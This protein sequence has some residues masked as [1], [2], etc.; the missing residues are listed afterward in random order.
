MATTIVFTLLLCAGEV[1]SSLGAD[2]Y[3]PRADRVSTVVAITS[4]R[5]MMLMDGQTYALTQVGTD[6]YEFDAKRDNG[7]G[8]TSRITGSIELAAARSRLDYEASGFYSP[9]ID[10][11][12]MITAE[13]KVR[14]YCQQRQ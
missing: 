1:S 4:D 10:G 12:S 14:A 5:T 7:G 2:V 3:N 11:V 13:R 9:P 6:F 8:K